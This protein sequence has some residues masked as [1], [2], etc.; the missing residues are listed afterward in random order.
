MVDTQNK[1]IGNKIVY[2]RQCKCCGRSFSTKDVRKIFC[3]KRCTSRYHGRLSS[4][5][6]GDQRLAQAKIRICPCCHKEFISH[7]KHSKYCSN[8]CLRKHYIQT[9]ISEMKN[10]YLRKILLRQ[11]RFVDDTMIQMKKEQIMAFRVIRAY[12]L[13]N[14]SITQ[15]I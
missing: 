14:R 4:R 5:K 9:E 2:T 15:N 8:R 7:K 11:F 3:V 1:R 13:Y 12:A 6:R 10:S